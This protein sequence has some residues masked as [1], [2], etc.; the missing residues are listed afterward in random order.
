MKQLQQND[1][2]TIEIDHTII[3][4]RICLVA[5]N[6][7]I[8]EFMSQGKKCLDFVTNENLVPA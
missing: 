4:A 2:V 1:I 7:C 5:V 3:T 6:G 8:V